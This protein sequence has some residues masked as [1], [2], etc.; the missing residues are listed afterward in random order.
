[1]NSFK[2]LLILLLTGLLSL[3]LWYGAFW[4][5]TGEPD[6]VKWNGGIKLVSFALF[7][8]TWTGFYEE[9]S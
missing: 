1:M 9:V 7:I 8:F 5:F 6:F 2:K 4:F 3:C